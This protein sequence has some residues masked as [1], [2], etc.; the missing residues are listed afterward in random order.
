[1]LAHIVH[2]LLIEMLG[3]ISVVVL[4]ESLNQVSERSSILLTAVIHKIVAKTK[5]VLHR[6]VFEAYSKL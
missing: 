6:V 3:F 4:K 2:V 1:M 5:H